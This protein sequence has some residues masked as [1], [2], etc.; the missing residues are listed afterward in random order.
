M[1]GGERIGL[2]PRPNYGTLA[3]GSSH[4]IME[5]WRI[6]YRTKKGHQSRMGNRHLVSMIE[7]GLNN[8][9]NQR[10]MQSEK[11]LE[12]FEEGL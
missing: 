1:F 11:K 12:L 8:G 6:D 7:K 5:G 9:F 3:K 10:M 4:V 2:L